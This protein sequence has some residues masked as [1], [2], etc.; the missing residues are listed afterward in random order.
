MA[1]VQFADRVEDWNS[2]R[3]GFGGR[4]AGTV[5]VAI[6]HRLRATVDCVGVVQV[7]RWDRGSPD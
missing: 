6:C 1:V 4:R 7:D 2:R 3:T 5:A